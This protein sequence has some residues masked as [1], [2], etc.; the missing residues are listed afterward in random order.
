[1]I[2]VSARSHDCEASRRVAVVVAREAVCAPPPVVH[3]VAVTGHYVATVESSASVGLCGT[4]WAG[5][6]VYRD[7]QD[8]ELDR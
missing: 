5:T 2:Q 6:R 7:P 3:S 1:M 8:G 4:L